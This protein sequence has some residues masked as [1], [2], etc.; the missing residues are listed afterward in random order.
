MSQQNDSASRETSHV[1]QLFQDAHQKMVMLKRVDEQMAQLQVRR[2]TLMDE[3]RS[4]QGNINDEFERMFNAPPELANRLQSL[5]STS[6]NGSFR[7]AVEQEDDE[8]VVA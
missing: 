7:D 5:T 2:R 6:R 3:L 1:V 4:V 8:S